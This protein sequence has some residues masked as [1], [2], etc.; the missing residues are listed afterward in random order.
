MKTEMKPLVRAM[1][2]AFFCWSAYIV[3]VVAGILTSPFAGFVSGFVTFFLV[4]GPLIEIGR[5]LALRKKRRKWES[6]LCARCEKEIGHNE[7]AYL[8]HDERVCGT[9][10][11]FLGEIAE[12]ELPKAPE[13]QPYD[14]GEN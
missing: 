9:C 1:V 8:W 13:K 7:D 11:K 6:G 4:F 3:L 10:A 2:I 14:F 5:Q 12:R